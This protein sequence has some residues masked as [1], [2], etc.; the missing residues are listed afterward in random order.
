MIVLRI[1]SRRLSQ[2][3]YGIT[4]YCYSRNRLQCVYHC[5][6]FAPSY[7]PP[8]VAEHCIAILGV[9]SRYMNPALL[10]MLTICGLEVAALFR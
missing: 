2:A 3:L 7:Y 10:L 6:I 4:T 9:T 5:N 8:R 1:G